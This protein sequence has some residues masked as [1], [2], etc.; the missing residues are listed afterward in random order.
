MNR[1]VALATSISAGSDIAIPMRFEASDYRCQLCDYKSR[2]S[3]RIREHCAVHTGIGY[4]VCKVCGERLR[5][6]YKLSVHVKQK[7]AVFMQ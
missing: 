6:A 4:F 2:N 5:T 1:A 3:N 7:H